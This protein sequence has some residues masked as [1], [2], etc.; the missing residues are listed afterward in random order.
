MK[1]TVGLICLV[2][3]V[4]GCASGIARIEYYENGQLKLCESKGTALGRAGINTVV[5]EITLIEE[6]DKTS[7]D[8]S[9][10]KACSSLDGGAGSTGM[11]ATIAAG[12]AAV[13]AIFTFLP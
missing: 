8:H 13:A 12:I 7:T 1:N 5:E 6:G 9:T 11:Y 2:F 10:L 4:S 3:C